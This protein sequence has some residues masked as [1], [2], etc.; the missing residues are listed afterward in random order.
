[1]PLKVV[2]GVRSVALTALRRMRGL[3]GEE[4]AERAG[5]SPNMASVY[6]TREEPSRERLLELAA[7]MEY[8]E[9]EVEGVIFGLS[10]ALLPPAEPRLPVDPTAAAARRIREIAG[11]AGRAFT[12]LLERHLVEAARLWMV[13]K[14][15]RQA[16]KL[17][18]ELEKTPPE[19]RRALIE[20][21][22]KF[23]TWA[24]S[25]RLAHESERAAS[26]KADRAL[27][28]AELG[29]R[30]SELAA[31]DAAFS[32]A[33]KGH[34][35]IFVANA[36][37][38]ANQMPRSG[39]DCDRALALWKAGAQEARKILPA[40]RVLDR[41]GS[42]RREQRRFPEAL[43]RLQEAQSLAPPKA[44]AR[45]LVNRAVVLEHMGDAEQAITVLQEAEA[46]ASKWRDSEL[47]LKIQFNLAASYCDLDRY[48]E[49][50]ELLPEIRRLAVAGRRELNL[51][52]V[53]WLSGRI[54]AG[55]GQALEASA[56]LNQ[57]RREFETRTMAYD[58]ALVCLELAE[59]DLKRGRY[60]EVKLLAEEMAWIFK[61][62]GIHREAL[63][64]VALFR[65]A[66]FEEKA[67]ADLARRLVRFLYRARY[68]PDLRFEP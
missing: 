41:E 58:Y 26:D 20:T 18:R 23:Q 5:I 63:A 47:K 16:G 54:D 51:I 61:D 3:T 34:A 42:I 67:S 57:V 60:A 53:L 40:W 9:E 25:E 64:A 66:A 17:W 32:S 15:R 13:K 24:M 6:E 68:N 33:V 52:R 65:K 55:F 29:F 19:R 43:E 37:R 46:H 35:L 8:G 36:R 39:E 38:V 14:A 59:L 7:A 28:L 31:G 27:A 56:A 22:R 10:R 12:E 49:A 30:V 1:M 4:L 62:Q 48:A 11:R 44:V 45:I 21:S 50:K 2:P